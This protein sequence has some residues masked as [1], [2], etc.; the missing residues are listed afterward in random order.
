M[1]LLSDVRKLFGINI[2]FTQ[3]VYVYSYDFIIKA[4]YDFTQASYEVDEINKTVTF[5]LPEVEVLSKEPVLDSFKIYIESES[6]F[7]DITLDE[8]NKALQDMQKQAIKQAKN[9]GLYEKAEENAKTLLE[10][11]LSSQYNSDE[12]RYQFNFEG[13]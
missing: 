6:K 4:G 8:N 7:N 5:T 12:Y 13:D 2:P 10:N 11:F 3:S 1:S 9:N